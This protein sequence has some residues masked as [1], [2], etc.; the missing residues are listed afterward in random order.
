MMTPVERALLII[1]NDEPRSVTEFG[2]LMW[3]AAGEHVSIDK[4]KRYWRYCGAMFTS[5]LCH[6]KLAE[7]KYMLSGLGYHFVGWRLTLHGE[8]V[9]A[10]ARGIM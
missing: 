3:P 1:R 8:Q 9:V 6:R 4:K 2:E 5:R 10:L 7:R